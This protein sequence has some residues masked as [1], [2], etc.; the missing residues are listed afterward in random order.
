MIETILNDNDAVVLAMIVHV[1]GSAYRKEGSWMLFQEDETRLGV[2]SGGC[3]ESDLQIRAQKLFHTGQVEVVQYDL[4]AEDDLGW[5]RGAGCNGVVTVFIR[6][7]DAAFIQFLHCTKQK[8]LAKEPVLFIQSMETFHHYG[9]MMQCG[10]QYGQLE[11]GIQFEWDVTTPFQQQSGQE[12]IHGEA[13]YC[14]LIW[15]TPNLY[16][17]GTGEDA[18]PLARLAHEVGYA[19]HLLDWRPSMCNETHFPTAMSF[20]TGNIGQLLETIDLSPLDSII[21]MTHD[22]QKDVDII[23]KLQDIRL[24]YLGILGSKKR[25]ARLFGGAIPKGIYSP[26]GLS[27]GA[28]GPAEIAV[29]IVAELIAVRRRKKG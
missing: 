21:I 1:E 11:E 23:Q 2:I 16:I 15:P 6:D 14:Q 4:S 10:R 13:L 12:K 22:F 27:I 28:D 5:G 17:I 8:L 20:R 29:S 24:L 25:T 9:G 19:V 3:I 7:V 26:V 18:R